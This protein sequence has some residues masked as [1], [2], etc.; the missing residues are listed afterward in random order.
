ML[1][2][3][4]LRER[5]GCPPG[6]LLLHPSLLFPRVPSLDPSTERLR[7]SRFS[8]FFFFFLFLLWV[9]RRARHPPLRGAGASGLAQP[10]PQASPG[11]GHPHGC[12]RT[13]LPCCSPKLPFADGKT[14]LGGLQDPPGATLP[15]ALDVGGKFTAWRSKWPLHCDGEPQWALGG[16]AH[17]SPRRE[18][19]QSLRAPG[20]A[21]SHAQ[22]SMSPKRI[23]FFFLLSPS[24]LLH[25]APTPDALFHQRFCLPL[26]GE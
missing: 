4:P 22:T 5:S 11:A 16:S 25:H 12:L 1:N 23:F 9:L 20:A 19:W 6:G 7:F 13:W 2:N 18:G 24:P 17:V 26:A 21:P 8:S 10:C 14:C 3:V 15:P